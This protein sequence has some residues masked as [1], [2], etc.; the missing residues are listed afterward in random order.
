[1]FKKAGAGTLVMSL[2][3]ASEKSATLF[4]STFYSRL[5]SNGFDVHDAFAKARADVR[6][7]FPEPF[8]WAGFI[9]VD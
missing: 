6:Q 5:A 2:W 9:L 7:S 3:E 4:M 8:Y 1:A